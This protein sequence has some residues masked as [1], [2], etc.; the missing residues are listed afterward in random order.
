MSCRHDVWV[1]HECLVSVKVFNLKCMDVVRAR[2]HVHHTSVCECKGR[3]WATD[4]QTRE[5]RV[6]IWVLELG[7]ESS[8][9]AASALNH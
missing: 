6:V 8:A 5:L 9:R 2:M 3:K 1:P 7:P 4:H